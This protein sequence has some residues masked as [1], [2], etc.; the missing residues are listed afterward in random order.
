[1]YTFYSKR[2]NIIMYMFVIFFLI[3]CTSAATISSALVKKLHEETGAR[4]M[5]CRKALADTSG[6]LV[7]AQ[8]FLRKKGLASAKKK[9]AQA[10]AEGGIDS[11]IHDSCIGV[12]VEV[13]C[14]T[15]FVSGGEN[16]RNW[17]RIWPCKWWHVLKSST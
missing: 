16:S 11:H 4:M 6:D 8:E 10:T 15:D 13:N 9:A 14:K 3:H 12:I 2:K 5:D 1:M 17:L 7:K